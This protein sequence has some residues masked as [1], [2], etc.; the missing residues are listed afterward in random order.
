MSKKIL[1]KRSIAKRRQVRSRAKVSGTKEQP[2]LAVFRSLRHVSV[3]LVDDSIK[4]TI[5]SASDKDIADADK[6][7]KKPVEVASMVGKIVGEKA[8][9]AGVKKAVFDRRSYKYH[10]R[11]KALA[12]G[13]REAGL[14]F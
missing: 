3:Q 4:K 10:G 9:K 14:E 11:V 5:A 6:K 8:V 7:G 12:D 13:A 2:R 1:K